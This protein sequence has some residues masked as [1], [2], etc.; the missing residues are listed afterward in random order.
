MVLSERIELSTSSLPRRYSTTELRQQIVPHRVHH[1]FPAQAGE[2]LRSCE[3]AAV[4]TTSLERV[5][6]NSLETEP[7]LSTRVTV[8]RQLGYTIRSRRIWCPWRDS[9]SQPSEPKSDASTNWATRALM[10]VTSGF[11]PPTYTMSTWCS[12]TE[13]SDYGDLGMTRTCD[14]LF[15]KQMLCPAELRDLEKLL[16]L[17]ERGGC[18]V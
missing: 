3:D 13:L 5:G 10:V 1:T 9:N 16:C 6:L 7:S 15:R 8:Q 17:F 18:M 14:P 4:Q 12:T 11:E 2:R